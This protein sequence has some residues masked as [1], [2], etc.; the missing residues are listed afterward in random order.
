MNKNDN[1]IINIHKIYILF[2]FNYVLIFSKT[3]KERAF[4][5]KLVSVYVSKSQNIKF[6]TAF[7]NCVYIALKNRGWK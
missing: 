7:R 6:K 1:H 5:N 3:Y 2:L 4:P